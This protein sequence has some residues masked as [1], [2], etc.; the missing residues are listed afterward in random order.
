MTQR[1]FAVIAVAVLAVTILA[2]T[3][4]AELLVYEPFDYSGTDIAAGSSGVWTDNV[5]LPTPKSTKGLVRSV[6][7]PLSGDSTSLA[8]P[9]LDGT[10]GARVADSGGGTASRALGAS[11]NLNSDNTYYASMLIRGSGSLQFY[12]GPY[13]DSTYYVR[14][15]LGI[16]DDTGEFF[17]GG[18]PNSEDNHNREV[19]SSS[20]SNGTYDSEETYLLVAKIQAGMTS[21]GKNDVFS[22]KIYDSSMTPDLTEPAFDP[23]RQ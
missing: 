9:D 8:H 20:Y 5:S 21:E 7:S 11:M 4:N 16:T 12:Y 3:S 18:Y 6:L 2:G 10:E 14:T 22:L 17:V 23:Q 13:S 19:Y 1:L 15:Y